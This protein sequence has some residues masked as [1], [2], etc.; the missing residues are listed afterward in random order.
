M[1]ASL[2]ELMRGLTLALALALAI[3][4]CVASAPASL[5]NGDFSGSGADGSVPAGW[6][7]SKEAAAKGSV[8]I[9]DGVLVLSPNAANTPSDTPLGLGQ[10]LDAGAFRGQQLRLSAVTGAT[11]EAVAVVG[12]AALGADGKVERTLLLRAGTSD[13]AAAPRVARDTE[14]LPNDVKLLIL[15][16]SAEGTSGKAT[17]DDIVVGI[18]K[19]ADA[20]AAAGAETDFVLDM[21]GSGRPVPAAVF[22]ANVEWIR[23]GNGLWDPKRGALSPEITGMAKAA[24]ITVIRFPGGVWSDTYDWRLGVGPRAAR[25]PLTHIPGQ[26]E[27]S[28][29]DLGT[30]EVAAFAKAIGARLM[31]TVNV[32]HGTPEEAGA[33][34]AYIR[35]HHGADVAPFWELGNELYMANDLSGGSMTPEAYAAKVRA[36]AAAIR[37]ELPQARIAAI[38]LKNYGPYR[39]NAYDKWND[40]VIRNAG[41][42]IDIL[43]VHNA[44]APLVL[45]TSP[46]AWTDVYRSMLAAPVLIAQNLR[47][48]A[49]GIDRAMPSRAGQITLAVTEWGPMFS[50]DPANPYFDHVKTLGSGIFV[51]RT[52]NTFLRDPRVEAATFFKLSDWL[53][54][55]WIGTTP[56]GGFRETPALLAFGL[57]RQTL[58]PTLLP[59]EETSGGSFFANARGFTGAVDDAPLVDGIA[60]RDGSGRVG[61]L[62]NNA[63]LQTARTVTVRLVNGAAAY[64]AS[65]RVLTGPAA[66]ANRGTTHIDVPGV[67]FAKPGVFDQDGWFAKSGP[68]TVAVAELAD[69]VDG[70]VLTVSIPPVSLA[71]I[72]LEPRQ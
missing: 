39:F 62:I 68:D 25:A 47:D 27:E 38:G 3:P 20:A 28:R 44:Y 21:S 15:F 70:A 17:F 54:M 37:H 45:D 12:L 63:D 31:I 33:W 29:P 59:L 57:Y 7:L 5:V 41:D 2:S 61:L 22:G 46:R 34:A 13:G 14:P 55:G 35:D 11:G 19:A 1:V 10:A 30:D 16:A 18:D 6:D 24:G 48:T 58:G 23:D 60:S 72:R 42:V 66:D 52:L 26:A 43:A 9:A 8:T 36:F 56:Q 69:S 51:A 49:A 40:V 32:G 65:A 53:N 50:V 64:T 4:G 71:A 67:P